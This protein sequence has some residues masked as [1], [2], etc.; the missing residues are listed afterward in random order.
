MSKLFKSFSRVLIIILVIKFFDIL[1]SLILASKLGVSDTSDVFM[2]IMVIPDGLIVLLGLDSIKGVVNSEY[3]KINVREGGDY[4]WK[5]FSNLFIILASFSLFLNVL[6]FFFRAEII[7]LFLPGFDISKK[8]IAVTLALIIFPVFIFKILAGT[9]HSVLNSIKRF[10]FPIAINVITTIA[11]IISV[12]VPYLYGDILYNLSFA[13]LIS[14]VLIFFITFYYVYKIGGSISF[15]SFT[16]DDTTKNI[17]KS[18]LKIIFLVI[19][20]QLFNFSKNFFASFYGEGAISSLNY[21][22]SIPNLIITLIFTTIFS[23]LLSNLSSSFETDKRA[24]S[25][26]IFVD[27]I[28]AIFFMCFPIVII[29]LINGDIIL[30]L[31]YLR[32]NFD[33]SGID[34]TYKPF[35]WESL[36][37]LSFILFMLPTAL[38][39]AKKRY[40]TLNLIGSLVYIAGIFANF[41]FSKYFGY[42][43]ISI[44]NFFITL[45]YGTLLIYYSQKFL[46]KYL[47]ELKSIVLIAISGAV[48]FFLTYFLLIFFSDTDVNLEKQVMVLCISSICI[49][50]FYLSVCNLLKVNY[51]KTIKNYF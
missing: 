34:K 5:S 38:Y 33:L 30:K 8:N 35:I 50:I 17:F 42:Y 16:L 37:V 11:L 6:I 26:K 23:I 40:K 49:I 21:A 1:K 19:C 20:D 10:N 14:N 15:T 25:R 46:G 36:S 4:L 22:R 9:I 41:L 24:Q 44:S 18:C 39:L 3:S 47:T 32:G 27:T 2:S 29:F 31:F 28:S 48:T 7:S 12:I 13:I 43:G 45:V 51:L